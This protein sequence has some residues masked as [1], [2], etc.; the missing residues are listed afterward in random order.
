MDLT[1]NV[2]LRDGSHLDCVLRAGSH[3]ECVSVQQC[4]EDLHG[5]AKLCPDGQLFQRYHQIPAHHTKEKIIRIKKRHAY[6]VTSNW[7]TL[8]DAHSRVDRTS[9]CI[10]LTAD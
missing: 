3:L 2:F 5:A 9:L 6:L 1:W 10:Y 8:E 7:W 4:N